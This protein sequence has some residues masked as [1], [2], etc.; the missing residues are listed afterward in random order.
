[1]YADDNRGGAALT[2]VAVDT[3]RRAFPGSRVSLITLVADAE[4]EQTHRHTTREHPDVELLPAAIP[5]PSG[6]LG[7]LRALLRSGLLLAGLDGRTPTPGTIRVR[8]ADVVIGKGG[9]AFSVRSLRGLLGFWLTLFPITLASRLGIPTVL[10]GVTIGPYRRWQPSRALAGLVLRRVSLVMARDARSESEALRLGVPRERV[11]QV[12]DTVF[13]LPAPPAELEAE[14]RARVGLDGVRFGA[15]TIAT[16]LEEDHELFD[17]LGHA[18]ERLLE[19]GVVERIAV[20]LQTDGPTTSDARASEAFV[21]RLGSP[22]VMLVR[23]DLS[24]RELCALY[25]S[26]A[27]TLACR[28]HSAILSL[29][30]GTPAFP[31]SRH[32]T[33]KADDIFATL[34][35][36]RFVVRVEGP[37]EALVATAD[38]LAESIQETVERGESGREE[39][40]EAVTRT[41]AETEV[42]VAHLQRVVA[43]EPA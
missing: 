36:Q 4:L 34:G 25:G 31:V 42:A 28:I 6:P 16:P 29:I 35:L 22:R 33:V 11:V 3:V 9:Q 41:R 30:A 23:D 7:G 10:Y 8:E 26:A 18:L 5:V 15:V 21:R 12:P 24:H 1:V 37:P 38:R 27:F 32:T 17:C 13:A 19:R 2:S 43:Y 14:V 40:R 39:I 20:V